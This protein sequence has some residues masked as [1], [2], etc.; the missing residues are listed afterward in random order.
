MRRTVASPAALAGACRWFIEAHQFRI[1]TADGIGRPTPEGAHR[2]G[3]DLVAV[4]LVDL[5]NLFY[6]SH[7]GQKAIAAAVGFAGVVGFFH[8][9]ICIGLMI[10]ITATVSRKIGAG[11]TPQ[12]Q[13]MATHS[14]LL[15]AVIAAVMAVLTVVLLEPLLWVLGARGGGCMHRAPFGVAGCWL[16]LSAGAGAAWVCTAAFAA[17]GRSRGLQA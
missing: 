6:I 7:L 17:D 5:I 11:H 2:D 16:P 14:L 9:S 1:D 8:T 13:R 15:M 10:G 4:F 12:A 3:V